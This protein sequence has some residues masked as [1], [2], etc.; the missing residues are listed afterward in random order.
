MR[1]FKRAAAAAGPTTGRH[2]EIWGAIEEQNRFLRR[3]AA[4]AVVWS[5]LAL[6]LAAYGVLVA[7]YRPLAFVVDPDGQATFVGRLRE[8]AEPTDGEARY[9]AK[10]FLQ[11]Y[12]AFN[13]LT[14]ESDLAEAWNR[15]TDELRAQQQQ[16]LAR[17]K[18]EHGG[19]EFVTYVKQQGIQ[20]VLD[21]DAARTQVTSHNGKS[22]TIR[23][24]GVMRTWPLNRVGDEAAF[25]QKDF[26]SY[27]TLVRCARTE[28]TPNGLLVAKVAT[29]TYVAEEPPADPAAAPQAQQ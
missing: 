8:Q 3:V 6:A 13:S 21:F 15:M 29:R 7:L 14:V 27:V 10:A 5:F 18:A 17:Y 26:E 28:Q 16:T 11:R 19:D 25:V 9:V 23:L 24:V 2:V 1:F 4:A 20:T 12:I 22:F